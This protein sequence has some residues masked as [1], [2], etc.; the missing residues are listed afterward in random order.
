MKKMITPDSFEGFNVVCDILGIEEDFAAPHSHSGTCEI[1]LSK[2]EGG[3]VIIKNK[4]YPLV[5]NGLYFINGLDVH[6]PSPTDAEKYFRNRI[7]LSIKFLNK[8]TD[9]FRL[10]DV[11]QKIFYDEGGKFCRLSA[12][13]AE[14]ADE[15]FKKIYELC[16]SGKEFEMA[17]SV[18]AMTEILKIGYFYNAGEETIVNKAIDSALEYIDSNIQNNITVDSISDFCGLN[19]YYMCHLFKLV[20][21]MTIS[22]YIKIARVAI[23]KKKLVYT[24]LSISEISKSTGFNSVSYFGRVFYEEE[25]VTPSE[26]R[27]IMKLG[28]KAIKQIYK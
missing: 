4:L 7:I 18:S 25:H 28:T 15:Y 2:T 9:F 12:A 14:K 1:I 23:A 6:H 16:Q 10:E 20:V 27:K 3:H 26:Y 13:K 11:V 24:N 17:D 22:K 19:K 8:L 21:G 5:K